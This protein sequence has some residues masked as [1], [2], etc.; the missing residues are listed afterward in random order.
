MTIELTNDVLIQQLGFNGIDDNG[1]GIP[2]HFFK[3]NLV[4][5]FTTSG[6]TAANKRGKIETLKTKEDV[7]IFLTRNKDWIVETDGNIAGDLTYSVN[8]DKP[9]MAKYIV[10]AYI[11]EHPK[12]CGFP[13]EESQLHDDLDNVKMYCNK[14]EKDAP[15]AYVFISDEEANELIEKYNL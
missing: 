3:D 5:H 11:Q 15:C 12:E 2:E 1:D 4:I 10:Q 7:Q 13:E 9:K 8:A 14:P 6:Y